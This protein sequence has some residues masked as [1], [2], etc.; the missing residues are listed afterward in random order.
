MHG[1]I[2]RF[3]FCGELVIVSNRPHEL[4][5]RAM[6]RQLPSFPSLRAF[7]SAARHLSFKVAAD[8]LCVTQS[9]ISHQVKILEEFLEAPLFIRRPQSVELTLRGSEYLE[10]ISHLMDGIESATQKVKGA[11]YEELLYVEA[12]PA[13]SSYW[14][15]PRLIRFS[16][17]YPGIEVNLSTIADTDS[18]ANNS[19]DVRINCSWEVPPESG[20]ERFM[21]SPHVP[22]CNP[23]LLKDGPDILQIEDLFQYPIVRAEGSWD[24]WDRWLEHIGYEKPSRLAGPRFENTYL[25]LKAA[26]EGLGIALAPTA[27]INEKVALG[28]LVVLLDIEGAHALYFTLTCAENWQRQP[29]ILAFREWLNYELGPCSRLDF[30]PIK[31]AVESHRT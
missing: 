15:L 6:K 3:T 17:T 1:L 31:L 14:L 29:K 24:K 5:S 12:S 16:Q 25:A 18:P 30:S 7:E 11:S 21:D 28:R 4:D 19:F 2:V 10:M 23:A 22:V 26:E 9:A 13:F 20:G 27:L 8:E